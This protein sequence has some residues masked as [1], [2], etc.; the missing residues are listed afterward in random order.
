MQPVVAATS[1]AAAI[2]ASKCAVCHGTRGQG[3]DDY[4]QPLF[5]DRPTLEL[6]DVIS[7]T[8]PDGEPDECVG[9]ESRAVA[10]WMQQEFYSPEAQARINPP[11][12]SLSRLTVSQYRNAVA[13][14]VASFEWTRE[15]DQQRGL[16]AQYYKSRR[17]RREDR[18]IERIDRTVAF[19]FGEGTPDAEKITD[20]EQFSITWR[21]SVIVDESGWYEFVVKTENGAKLFVN[22]SR[23]PLIDAWVKSGF[24]T[25]YKAS[26]FLLAGRLYP[27]TLE[28]FTFK[29]K[30]ASV[31]LWWKP[32][33]G[34]EQ[35]IPARH[36]SPLNSP[37]IV[38]VETPFPPDDR[39]DGYERGTSVS[40]AWYEATTHAAME[41]A[42]RIVDA[43]PR[44]ARTKKGSS[45]D[46]QFREFSRQFVERAFRRPL[47]AAE[48]AALVDIQFA[49]AE[50][51]EDAI[52]RVILRTLKSPHF[53]YREA[54]GQKTPYTIAS[55]LSFALID[56]IPDKDLLVA[57]EKGWLSSE[58][59]V[60]DQAR[61][62][63]GTF[64]SRVRMT[65]FLRT[66]LNLERLHDLS[67]DAEVFA[68]FTPDVAA[69]LRSSFERLLEDCV[70][71][72]QGGF[73]K[74]LT[75]SEF[76]INPRL[77]RFYDVTSPD[78]ESAD[79]TEFRKV[80]FQPEHR[81]GILGHPYL[82]SGLAYHTESSP[83][84]RGV[85][86][87]RSILGRALKPPP[88]SVAPIPPELE[89]DLTTRQRIAKQTSPDMCANCHGMINPLGF[90]LEHFDAVGRYR[91]SEKEQPIDAS[92]HYQSRSGQLEKFT[93]ARE[94]A[95][96]LLKSPETHRS[97][98]RQMFHH[99]VQQP[100][101]AFGPDTIQELTESFA[102]ADYDMK[103]L[104]VDISCRF[105]L[106]ENPATPE[107]TSQDTKAAASP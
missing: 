98:S 85:F 101:L 72:E 78:Q 95:G 24:D 86:L 34:V 62:L 41:A 61:R 37:E 42:D 50:S 30:T 16:E 44:I 35:V 77:A 92:G 74:L 5:G 10:E 3:T 29:E 68:D 18:V 87:S 66:W 19:D 76:W 99:M 103:H 88:D 9:E 104:M 107:L 52:R 15:P 82:L 12:I 4:P 2:F 59:G 90:S 48:L 26:R 102:K 21:G 63:A 17:T 38:V 14:L 75:T 43:L 27:V 1:D 80:T 28:W 40:A 58:Q 106:F 51:P 20:A 93:G 69:D 100:I 97:F 8:M 11:Q 60:R 7:R 39:S 65:E 70:V 91:A 54:N 67:K 73:Q 6:A 13:D 31:G 33:H 56:S 32:P 84:H 96:F 94:L 25:Q 22:D 81:A 83:I 89:A 79:E 57:A 47:S 23:N 46:D 105:A 36:L 71:A 55:R 53:L 45:T 64:R 49:D